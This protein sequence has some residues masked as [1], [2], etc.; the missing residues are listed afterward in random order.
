LHLRSEHERPLILRAWLRGR[1]DGAVG[2]ADE[3]LQAVHREA[4]D[5]PR[6]DLCLPD[7]GE[8]VPG[9]LQ[10]DDQPALDDLLTLVHL[11]NGDA[12]RD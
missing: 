6:G 5:G 1:E 3:E 10:L 9:T 2:N 8:L 7:A 4:V 11:G 12:A